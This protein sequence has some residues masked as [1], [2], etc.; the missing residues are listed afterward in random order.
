MVIAWGQKRYMVLH[1]FRP[2]F[3]NLTT[4][5]SEICLDTARRI[6]GSPVPPA[7]FPTTQLTFA[8]R[9]KCSVMFRELRS[10]ESGQITAYGWVTKTLLLEKL[11]CCQG[12]QIKSP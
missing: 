12:I 6:E 8:N 9:G 4:C 10:L 11:G 5:F 3:V 2:P 7:P 1:W